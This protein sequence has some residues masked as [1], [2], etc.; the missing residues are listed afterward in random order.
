MSVLVSCRGIAKAWPNGGGLA[1]TDIDLAAGQL[2]ALCGRS[3]SGK[4][5]LLSIIAGWIE[6]SSGTVERLPAADG[7]TW[8]ST[9]VVPQ[10]LGLVDELS[11]IENID[12]PV[13]LDP[14]GPKLDVAQLIE[15]L[16]LAEHASR[17]PHEISLGQRQRVALARALVVQP[18]LIL[19]DEPTSHQDEH[20]ADVVMT[21]IGELT[22]SGSAALIATHDERTIERADT[23]IRLGEAPPQSG[24][25][26][27]TPG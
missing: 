2:T 6:P 5:T 10:A 15:R 14:D 17:L 9:A 20:N 18:T 11:V 25:S 16:D 3:G 12:L 23:V 24:V 8:R 27:E 21:L 1:P 7:S 19:V 26:R 22:D 13:R 4:T